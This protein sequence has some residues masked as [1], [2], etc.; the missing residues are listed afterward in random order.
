[1]KSKYVARV[2]CTVAGAVFAAGDPVPPGV[3]LDAM[4]AH[5]DLFVTVDSA[6]TRAEPPSIKEADK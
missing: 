3:A 6:R 1:M 5:G 4:L 2:D